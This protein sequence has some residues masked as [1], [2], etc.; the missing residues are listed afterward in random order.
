M[1]RPMN[2]AD[3]AI[4]EREAVA[5]A[6][7]FECGIFDSARPGTVQFPESIDKEE[8]EYLIKT[9]YLRELGNNLYLFPAAAYR[10]YMDENLGG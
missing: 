9:C 8:R 7:L 10:T 2:D 5:E 6:R 3:K 1:T 4:F